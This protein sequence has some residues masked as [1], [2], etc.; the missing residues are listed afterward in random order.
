MFDSSHRHQTT[1]AN[2]SGLAFCFGRRPKRRGVASGSA[3]ASGS[4]VAAVFGLVRPIF[5]LGSLKIWRTCVP[6]RRH[7][8]SIHA[9]LRRRR[10]ERLDAITAYSKALW[11]GKPNL[12]RGWLFDKASSPYSDT[13]MQLRITLIAATSLQRDF[14]PQACAHVACTPTNGSDRDFGRSTPNR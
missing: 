8:A 9:G 4:T 2:P 1:K 3:C 10:K 6:W 14:H 13:L 12:W 11:G 5:A 7:K